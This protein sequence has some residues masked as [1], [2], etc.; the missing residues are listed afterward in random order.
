MNIESNKKLE[1]P[2]FWLIIWFAVHGFALLMSYAKIRFFNAPHHPHYSY[3]P[4][5]PEQYFWPFVDFTA[6]TFYPQDYPEGTTAYR[7]VFN[8]VFAY[9]DWTEFVFYV[10]LGAIIYLL[11]HNLKAF[12]KGNKNS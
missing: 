12:F 5:N 1:S 6:G 2:K 4:S 11:R 10:G 9:Y 7:A 3:P 8:G